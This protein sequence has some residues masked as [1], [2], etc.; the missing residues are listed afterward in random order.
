MAY[1]EKSLR[2]KHPEE[3]L[4]ILTAKGNSGSFTY[5]GI[6]LGAERVTHEVEDTLE[7]LKRQG[8]EIKKLSVVGYSLG[9]LVARYVVG[10]LYSNGWFSKLEPVNFTTFATPHLGVRT[11]LNSKIELCTPISSMTV[12]PHITQHASP[13][14]I[15][16]P[17]SKPSTS[18][19]SPNTPPTSSTRPTPSPRKFHRIRAL[20]HY[21][22]AW[23]PA[24]KQS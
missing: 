7:E 8:K 24:A 23:R 14:P 18:T 20:H 1:V 15:H 19:T 10:L 17:T 21:Q 22:P 4:H 16:S 6:E 11:P 3:K 2:N 5:D 12:P 13:K 9:G